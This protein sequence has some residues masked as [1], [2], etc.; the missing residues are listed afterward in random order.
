MRHVTVQDTTI[1]AL[2]FGTFE[3]NGP[4]AQAL[5]S[6]AVELGYRHFDTAQMYG[7]EREVGAGLH[8]AGI[9]RSDVFITSKIWPDRFADG[10]LQA[11]AEQSRDRLGI[12]QLDLL[13][14]HWP[15]TEVPLAETIAALNEVKQAG[16]ARDIGVSNFNLRLLDQAISLSAAPLLVNQVEYHPFLSQ[17]TLLDAM[18]ARDLALVA[19]CP[20]ARGQVLHDPII[21]RIAKARRKSAAQITLR[22]LVQQD[23]VCA[24]PRSSNKQRAASNFDVFDFSLTEQEMAQV[25]ALARPGGRLVDPAGLSPTWD[26]EG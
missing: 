18:R 24:I 14:L 21:G 20:L 8:D 5:V 25:S 10:E 15:S 13:L 12:E 9:A 3:L 11:A 2:G 23:G 22:W 4:V 16:L 26:P 7:N 6:R 17:Q 1:P 19:Y